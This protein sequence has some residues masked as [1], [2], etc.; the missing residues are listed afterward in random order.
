[1]DID[2]FKKKKL[3]YEYNMLHII[4]GVLH[5]VK[6]NMAHNQYWIGIDVT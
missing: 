6:Y 2:F 1:M 5:I 4:S 3:F